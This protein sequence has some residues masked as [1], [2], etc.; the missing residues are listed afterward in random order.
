MKLL[1]KL[2]LLFLCLPC[3]AQ[4]AI[5]YHNIIQPSVTTWHNECID[6]LSTQEVMIIADMLLLS[7]QVVQ[8]S[9]IMSQARLVI[10]TELLNIVTLSINDTFDARMQ[11]ENNDLSKIKQAVTEIEY[12]QE[13]MKFACNKLK[14]F[15]PILIKID[16]TVIQIFIANFKEVILNWAKNQHETMDEFEHVQEEFSSTANL[17]AQVKTIFQT[18]IT[19]NPIEHSQL[20]HG[21]NSLTNMYNTIE[22]ML[23]HLTDIR[24]KSLTHFNAILTLYFKSHYQ[25]LYNHLQNIDALDLKLASTQNHTLPNPELIFT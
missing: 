17:F 7:Y 20:L 19:K 12:A 3:I 16:P 15:A 23:A 11:A 2:F 22:N 10:Q 21:T 1:F 8:A 5:D 14:G 18:I 25:I 6:K 24:Q 13:K 4:Q 9:V